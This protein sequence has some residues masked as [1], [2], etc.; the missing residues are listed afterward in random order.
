MRHPDEPQ[1]GLVLANPLEIAATPYR[2]ADQYLGC[3]PAD[4]A[5]IREYGRMVSRHKLLIA[6]A[7]ILCGVAGALI[8]LPQSPIYRAHTAI[9]VEG[10]N[11]TTNL[12]DLDPGATANAPPM[13]QPN[14]ESQ[15][16]TLRDAALVERTLFD[17][18][19]DKRAASV[20]NVSGTA[21][22]GP[23][24]NQ[25]D[26]AVVRTAMRQLTVEV[27]ADHPI[28]DIYFDCTDPHVGADFLNKLIDNLNLQNLESKR[29][30]AHQLHIWLS[31]E[32][33]SQ[34]AALEA[35]SDALQSY[36]RSHGLVN[37]DGQTNLT[38]ERLR[39]VQDEL[40]RAHA[41]RLAAQSKYEE[42]R[43]AP[44]DALPEVLDNPVLRDYELK[45]TDLRR[46]LAETGV[47]FQSTYP[48]VSGVQAQITELEATIRRE[49]ADILKR[50]ENEYQSSVRHEELLARNYSEQA[51]AVS[52]QA[53][54][55]SHYNLLKREVDANRTLYDTM[56]Q[57]VKVASVISALQASNIRVL[58][59][60]RP[61]SEPFKPR[62]VFNTIMG[63]IAGCFLSMA[64]VFIR[65]QTDRSLK[66]PG[67]ATRYLCVPE[68]GLIPS[69]S[70]QDRKPE[71]RGVRNVRSDP[72]EQAGTRSLMP[73]LNFLSLTSRR[74]M[75]QN[76][77]L[78]TWYD[79]SS[80]LAEA[81]RIVIS[82]L[83]L[84]RP[85]M[86]RPRMVVFASAR[87]GDGK[88]T[89]ASN[90]A[91]ALAES[92]RVLLIDGDLRKP[93]LHRLFDVPKGIGLGDVLA[94]TDDVREASK[95]AI[96]ATKV[97]NLSLL[98]SGSTSVKIGSLKYYQRLEQ[99]FK[100]LR[101]TFDAVII[102]TPPALGIADARIFA[103][104]SD[105][106][107]F[108]VRSA[109]TTRDEASAAL[110]NFQDDGTPVIGAVLNQWNP[111][112]FS[113][114][115]VGYHQYYRKNVCIER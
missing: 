33:Q 34:K 23:A 13:D 3:A 91:I 87:S 29:K 96:C 93:T 25:L 100:H 43:S 67:D 71:R 55:D 81:M 27:S 5:G 63:V 36:A 21:D 17:L 109:E 40:S 74:P 68:L 1:E 95:A 78:A 19:S 108:V 102:D 52:D 48:K 6:A 9:E 24:N 22:N 69:F 7:A 11:D 45:L 41:D 2:P 61:P 12:K 84:P 70:R 51:K 59:P 85:G 112:H 49:R 101:T 32:L 50:I 105:V 114:G 103:R 86:N 14:T 18:S 16:R 10:P 35:S 79:Q 64:F 73:R 80:E 76:I 44:P 111:K 31:G 39:Q 75:E 97:P 90:V 15:A 94:A 20:L 66:R 62:P 37:S 53:I 26:D 47:V 104:V 42:S 28:I 8:S 38:E 83:W 89:L 82:S 57:K 60:A 110:S 92:C 107:V 88:T 99:L 46:Q 58:S 115:D 98:P 72:Q 54:I 113:Y 77:A 30:S 65:E 106:V 56:L 4:V